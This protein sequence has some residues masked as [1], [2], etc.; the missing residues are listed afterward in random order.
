MFD[1]QMK[2]FELE[3]KPQLTT[4]LEIKEYHNAKIKEHMTTLDITVT[5]CNYL[6]K[7]AMEL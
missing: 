5:N 2:I 4:P 3:L 7:H 1:F 6:F